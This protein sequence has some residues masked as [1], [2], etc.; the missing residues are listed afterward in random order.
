MYSIVVAQHALTQGFKKVKVTRLLVM[1][2]AAGMGLYVDTTA[3][4]F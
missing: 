2:A 3:Y 4:V 1:R